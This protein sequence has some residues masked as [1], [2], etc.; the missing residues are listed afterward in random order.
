[1]VGLGA[2]PRRG[3]DGALVTQYEFARA[4]IVTEEMVYVAHRENLAR[5]A[6]VEGARERLADGESFGAAIA[7]ASGHGLLAALL[8]RD[9]YVG[10]R[11]GIGNDMK[12]AR[13]IERLNKIFSKS[14]LTTKF[15]SLFY[16]EFDSNGDIVYVNAGH[17]SPLH[18]HAAHGGFSEMPSTGMVLGP[19]PDAVY[20]R[21]ATH[22]EHGDVVV[23][24][25]DGVVE[26]HDSRGREYGPS[27]L[28][29][30]VS[31]ARRLP[32]RE[33]ALAMVFLFCT[34]GMFLFLE[35]WPARL[36][37]YYLPNVFNGRSWRYVDILVPTLVACA[38]L[39]LTLPGVFDR[40]VLR[41]L[42]NGL[43]GLCFCV[44][45]YCLVVRYYAFDDSIADFRQAAEASRGS[46]ASYFRLPQLLD[47]EGCEQFTQALGWPDATPLRAVPIHSL[48]LT[49]SPPVCIW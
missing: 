39:I 33:R 36:R 37:P 27:R 12:I 14:R 29:R 19:M 40:K 3:R 11:M 10:L 26:A 9:I 35:F 28:K 2:V 21:R 34:I 49:N 32:A 25:T 41:G 7:D 18:L 23:L 46:L 45:G 43:L 38:A 48:D 5:E 31:E 16:G 47:P 6:A 15:V 44:A 42:R 1:V 4:G 20:G 30:L 13:T 8:V 24:Y 22:M 17:P